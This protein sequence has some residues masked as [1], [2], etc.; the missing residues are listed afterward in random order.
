MS[1]ADRKTSPPVETPD[2]TRLLATLLD[3]FEEGL[4]VHI[5]GVLT[6][7]NDAAPDP[8]RDLE[9]EDGFEVARERWFSQYDLFDEDGDSPVPISLGEGPVAK[10]MAGETVEHRLYRIH[11]HATGLDRYYE[12]SCRPFQL[13]SDGPTGFVLTTLDLT[14]RALDSKKLAGTERRRSMLLDLAAP[15]SLIVDRSGHVYDRRD[16][17]MP[18]IA[19][20][21]PHAEGTWSGR[22]RL[23]C[24]EDGQEC[25]FLE[26]I[27]WPV[28]REGATVGGTFEIES[29]E[30]SDRWRLLVRGTCVSAD[31]HG[32]ELPLGDCALL[33]FSPIEA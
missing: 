17:G 26:R 29:L 2:L 20:L 24:L 13:D 22:F 12:T 19:E 16:G 8:L 32:P 18:P 21:D 30:S 10:A 14:D 23:T 33:T 27:V 4:L 5:P 28:L 9:L 11:Q 15:A 1:R 31:R 3:Q 7:R 6:Y 25:S